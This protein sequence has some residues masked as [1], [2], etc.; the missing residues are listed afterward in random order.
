MGGVR[1]E[2]A[3]YLNSK[4]YRTRKGHKFN[5]SSF[6]TLIPNKTYIGIND[7]LDIKRSCPAI[8]DE[9]TWN[10]AQLL[11][12]KLKITKG[13]KVVD[14]VKYILSGKLF[15]G[16]CGAA[17]TGVS[18][19]SRSGTKHYY[20][21][22]V[23]RKKNKSCKKKHE[24][25]DY[26]EWYVIEQTIE[27]VLE[28]KRLRYISEKVA[29]MYNSEFSKIDVPALKAHLKKL[30]EQLN[31]CL[32]AII[33]NPA[34]KFVNQMSDKYD[35]LLMQKED[36]SIQIEEAMI[37][38]Q[39]TLNPDDV[40]KWL[41]TFCKG[42]YFDMDFRK[43]IVDVLVHSIYLF[44]DKIVIYYNVTGSEEVSYIDMISDLDAFCS[45]E[46]PPG[47]FC[48]SDGPPPAN[49]SER[50]YLYIN[51]RFGIVITR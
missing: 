6:A 25:K 16:M 39:A 48:L 20:Y 51:N 22:C 26:L 3:D 2:I 5:I 42:D 34:K 28:P 35:E 4:G 49:Q 11:N 24:L 46:D 33:N 21:A 47:S 41:L 8:I 12:D 14:D 32:D 45:D 19:T 38:K 18:G 17:M 36:I 43:K 1:E 40:E 30:D 13:H 50:I 15:C 23:N 44:D 10:Q 9:E 37:S 27:Y 29:E 7:Y 31:A